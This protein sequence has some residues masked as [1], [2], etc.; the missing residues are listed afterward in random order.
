MAGVENSPVGCPIVALG[1]ST[2]HV[3]CDCP[4]T[5][6]LSGFVKSAAKYTG[7]PGSTFQIERLPVVAWIIRLAFASDHHA[8]AEVASLGNVFAR[9]IRGKAVDDPIP[10][11]CS[12]DDEDATETDSVANTFPTRAVMVAVPGVRPAVRITVVWPCALVTVRLNTVTVAGLLEV[13]STVVSGTGL[14][15]ASVTVNPMVSEASVPAVNT[16]GNRP[17]LRCAADPY[18]VSVIDVDSPSTVAVMV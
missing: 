13:Q 11:L 8:A 15:L 10:Q 2:V 1:L 7:C 5:A 4:D 16:D 17:N 12:N 3:G 6:A 18:T 9:A 14:P